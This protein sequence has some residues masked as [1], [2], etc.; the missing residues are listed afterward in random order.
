MPCI[1]LFQLETYINCNHWP[2][3]ISSVL[4]AGQ[5][6]KYLQNKNK[7]WIEKKKEGE[8][9]GKRNRNPEAQDERVTSY[10]FFLVLVLVLTTLLGIIVPK[11]WTQTGL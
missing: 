7:N 11:G 5:W 10:F 4:F 3:S 6:C 8:G 2:A 1:S 9:N